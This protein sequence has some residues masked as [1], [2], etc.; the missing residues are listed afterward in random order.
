MQKDHVPRPLNERIMALIQ[1]HDLPYFTLL[2]IFERRRLQGTRLQDLIPKK[3]VVWDGHVGGEGRKYGF[4]PWSIA[5]VWQY[6][7]DTLTDT[8]LAR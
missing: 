3:E 5:V 8:S 6:E 1:R 7:V 4:Y 2:C